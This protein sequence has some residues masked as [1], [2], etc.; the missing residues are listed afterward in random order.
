[1]ARVALAHGR[2]DFAGAARSG[3]AAMA[4]STIFMTGA[5]LAFLLLPERLVGPFLDDTPEAAIVLAF[6]A[7]FLAVAALFQIVDGLQ[8]TAGNALRGLH[9]TKGPMWLAA[10][11]YWGIGFPT[12]VALGFGTYLEGV[13]IWIGMATGLAAT[14][15]LLIHRF[16]RKTA[17]PALQ[18]GV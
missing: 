2:G 16:I 12:C 10:L 14:A 11:G 15:A 6:G 9:D 13:G 5:A 3:W 17:I 8:V 4:L 1:M 7:R 18:G